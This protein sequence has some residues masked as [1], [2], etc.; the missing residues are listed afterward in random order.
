M[1]LR[2]I[3]STAYDG[4]L[5]MTIKPFK[6]LDLKKVF[7]Y[8]SRCTFQASQKEHLRSSIETK[9]TTRLEPRHEIHYS[10]CLNLGLSM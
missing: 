7:Y 3:D 10:S 4:G 9:N 2:S 8:G 5:I 1:L 6:D